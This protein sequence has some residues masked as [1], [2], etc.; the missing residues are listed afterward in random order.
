VADKPRSFYDLVSEEYPASTDRDRVL[1]RLA[2]GMAFNVW[3]FEPRSFAAYCEGAPQIELPP[4]SGQGEPIRF[5][6]RLPMCLETLAG[7]ARYETQ[8]G[9][10]EASAKLLRLRERLAANWSFPVGPNG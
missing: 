3:R 2:A 1:L 4:P 9:H 7:A 5:P 10:E 6:Y 8:K